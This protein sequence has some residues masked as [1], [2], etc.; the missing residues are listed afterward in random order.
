MCCLYVFTNFA[1]CRLCHTSSF[2]FFFFFND[3]A[4]TEIYTLSLH[5]ALP[6][7]RSDLWSLAGRSPPPRCPRSA[8]RRAPGPPCCRSAQCARGGR[9][10]GITADAPSLDGT[11]Q[12]RKDRMER[13]QSGRAELVGFVALVSPFRF[14]RA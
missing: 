11:P 4:T 1:C 6:V 13:S 10:G 5:D 8:S 2:F 12:A 7:A 14:A 3:P 9:S